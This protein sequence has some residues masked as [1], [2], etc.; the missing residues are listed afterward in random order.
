MAVPSF[1]RV[2]TTG[3]VHHFV[4]VPGVSGVYYLGTAE[5]TPKMATRRFYS[6]VFNDLA[7]SSLP[8]Q[9]L[10]H[11]EAASVAVL[12]TRFS[13][14]ALA[15]ALTAGAAAGV[16]AGVGAGSGLSRGSLVFG[17]Q[18][19]ELWQRFAYYNTLQGTTGLVQGRYWPQV[20]LSDFNDE[21]VGTS[22][23]KALCVF[24]AQPLYTPQS[25]NSTGGWTLVRWDDEAFPADVQTPE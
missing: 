10:D 19:F 12:L 2:H 3:P 20:T 16:R 9:R 21:G 25:S 24:D 8:F 4:R 6:D 5:V 18:S 7:G 11:G 22:G 1:P 13:Y 14:S 23:Y 17:Q 15:V